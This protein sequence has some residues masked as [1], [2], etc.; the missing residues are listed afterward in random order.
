ME[1]T[2]IRQRRRR[3][4]I[5]PLFCS[6]LLLAGIMDWFIGKGEMLVISLSRSCVATGI[7]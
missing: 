6:G 1:H 2:N 5:K 7:G 4:Y 3:D